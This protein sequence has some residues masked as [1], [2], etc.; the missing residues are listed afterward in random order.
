MWQEVWHGVAG[1]GKPNLPGA[2][3]AW[4]VM[5]DGPEA[6]RRV[7]VHS[8]KCYPRGDPIQ[9]VLGASHC[10]YQLVGFRQLLCT[11]VFSTKE[12]NVT[13]LEELQFAT[14]VKHCPP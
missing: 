5:W 8:F 3:G 6:G 1:E 7:W 11:S 9:P 13:H 2:H 4:E 10:T 12:D 14:V